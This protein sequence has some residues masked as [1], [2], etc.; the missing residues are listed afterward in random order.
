MKKSAIAIVI[1]GA[2]AG[3]VS[4]QTAV[5]SFNGYTVEIELYGDTFAYG[6]EEARQVQLDAAR[7][8]AEDVCGS[9]ARFLSRRM[10]AQPQNGMFY[11]PSRNLALFQCV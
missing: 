10:E 8:Q 3:C 4:T 6:S 2:L 1:L 5:H 9:S 11:V 7:V